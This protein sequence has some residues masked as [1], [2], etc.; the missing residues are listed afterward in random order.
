MNNGERVSH[1]YPNDCFFAH[2][3]IYYFAAQYCENSLVLDAGSGAGYGSAYLADHGAKFV[4]GVDIGDKAVEFSKQKFQ[5][6]N[7]L[8]QV[9]DLQDLSG[10]HDQQFDLIYSSNTLEHV[11]NVV[12]FFRSAW[13]LLKENGKMV[14][15]VPPITRDVDWEENNRNI[16]H[17]NIWTPR[18]WYNVLDLYFSEIQPYWLGFN[19][20]GV[21]LDFN[22]TPEQTVINEKDFIFIPIPL[23][24]YYTKPSL[25]VTFVVSKP[26]LKNAIP[27]ADFQLF[28]VE[29][30]YTRP[31]VSD[32]VPQTPGLSP[33]R[34]QS[35]KYMVT[36]AFTVAREEGFSSMLRK[37]IRYLKPK[38]SSN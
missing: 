2:L 30:S 3:S 29:G 8:Y 17:L 38:N 1:I 11:P 34:S 15:T 31:P 12:N 26:R 6:A 7:L 25:G 16:Y 21:P 28:F 33:V 9:M 5:R 23:E 18:Q 35:L 19:K 14:I 13:R 4:W 10:F 37:I 36:R 20:P 32:T 27:A 22:N 24:D